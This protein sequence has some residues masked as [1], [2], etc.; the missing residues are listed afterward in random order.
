MDY[1]KLIEYIRQIHKS[2]HKIWFTFEEIE[3]II[4]KFEK[5]E[6]NILRQ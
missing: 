5:D 4:K 6:S 2:E 1:N 3:Q